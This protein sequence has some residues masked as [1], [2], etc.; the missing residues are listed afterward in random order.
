MKKELEANITISHYRIVS[1]IGA[2]GMGE[3]Y[4]AQDTSELGRTVA[5][6]ILSNE[7][8]GNKDRLQRFVREART[9]S[10]L[11]HPNILTVHEFGTDEST[12]FMAT[13]FVDGVTLRQHVS[14]RRLK[15][16][17]VLDVAIQI[18]AALNAAHEAGVTHRDLKPENVMVRRDHIVK[19]LDFG[20]AKHS[21]PT[22]KN[23]IDSE[24]GTKVLVHTEPGIVMGTV[25]YMSPEQSVGREVDQRSDIWSAGVVLYEMISGNLPFTGKDIHRQIIAIQEVEPAPL[26]QQVE[27]VPERL[28]EIV[29][30]CL[31]KEKDERYQSA[32]DLLIDLR[33]LRR[34]LDV[35]AEIERTVAP[36]LRSTSAGASQ[37][38]TPRTYSAAGVT[39][40]ERANPTSSAEH[41]VTGIKQHRLALGL[42]ALVLLVSV[43]GLGLY[44][45]RAK[46]EDSIK[47]I[48]VMPFE[49]RS[50]NADSE[51]L[52]D[53]LAESLIYRLSQLP[54][55]KVS[56]TS[57]V[58][59]YK[60]KEVDAQKIGSELG[61]S[62]VMTCRM[63][64]RG[65]N[66]TLSVELIDV[67][68]NKLIWGEQY[69]RKLSELLT[70][71]REIATEIAQNLKLKLTGEGEQKLAKKYT[72]SSDAYQLYLKGT[73][74][75]G[76]RT[77]EDLQKAIDYFQQAIKLDPQFALA[78]VG[79]SQT[80][81]TMTSYSY[82]SPKDGFSQAKPAAQKALEID[83]SLADAHAALALELATYDWNWSEA[84]RE[85]KRAVELNPNVAFIHYQY[86]LSYLVPLKR[87]D[88]GIQEIKRALE[89]EPLS[90]PM[91]ANLGGAYMYAR[92][93]DAALEQAKKTFDLD[94]T[95]VTARVWLETI[96]LSRG[97]YSETLALID[98]TLKAHPSDVYSLNY[99]AYAYAK[100]G[101]RPEAEAALNKLREVEKTEPVDSYDFAI[102]YV[103][104]GDK[105]RAL[106]ELEKNFEERGF[107]MSFL[108]VDPLMDPLRDDPRFKSLVKRVGLP[109]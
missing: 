105:E 57:S 52:S 90:I 26:S 49:N 53:G 74:H 71:Q 24:A 88:E 61:V 38:S 76:K 35:D 27:G 103:G 93:S 98:A 7:V 13:E 2:G 33:N 78:Y 79:I 84:E 77:K 104:L 48:A 106:A 6:K 59:R 68:S 15:L 32:K 45:R 100:M 89:L 91:N 69:E 101:R 55:L 37:T 47:S 56:P 80:Y 5:L 109:Q 42:A 31:A 62:A 40:P 99:A 19:V 51:Y 14:H 41:I 10:N 44:L 72:D 12:S 16:L 82:I 28:E 20:L 75:Y 30:K 29:T 64:Q 1:K 23:Q 43:I 65:D 73:F 96:Y 95:H 21:D 107:Y 92:Q 97:M 102:V 87:T 50:G 11:N 83:P 70:T 39:I 86:G 22:P 8:A 34:K 94:P 58:K 66:L 17:E 81:S 9:V 85:F 25:S 54:D 3:V 4:L 108:Q 63:M 18:V 67:R 36:N 46:N 60:G